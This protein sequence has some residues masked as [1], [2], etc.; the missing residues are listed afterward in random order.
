MTR[1][2]DKEVGFAM[3]VPQ[4]RSWWRR[5]ARWLVPLIVLAAALLF[6]GLCVLC[7]EFVSFVMGMMKSCDAYKEGLARAKAHPAVQAALGTPIKDGFFVTGNVSTGGTSGKADLAVPISGPK[8]KATLCVV[9]SKSAGQW[10]FSTL[11]VE[12]KGSSENISLLEEKEKEPRQNVE[13][14]P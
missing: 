10:S 13:R 9:A 7:V 14:A 5:N 12:V 4:R 2:T 3:D 11:A 8:G 1:A 6:A